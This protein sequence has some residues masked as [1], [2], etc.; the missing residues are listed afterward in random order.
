MTITLP[1]ELNDAQPTVNPNW[2]AQKV[3]EHL[4]APKKLANG[5]SITKRTSQIVYTAKRPT[6]GAWPSAVPRSS[7]GAQRT[8]MRRPGSSPHRGLTLVDARKL[9]SGHQSGSAAVASLTMPAA[10]MMVEP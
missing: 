7:G 2:T 6:S 10:G 8:A 3:T 5:T 9:Q 4:P 1:A